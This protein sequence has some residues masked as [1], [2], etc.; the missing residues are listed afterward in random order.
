MKEK[1]DSQHYKPH[2]EQRG[3]TILAS[4]ILGLIF[5]SFFFVTPIESPGYIRLKKGVIDAKLRTVPLDSTTPKITCIFHPILY[6]FDEISIACSGLAESPDHL[7]WTLERVM[8]KDDIPVISTLGPNFSGIIDITSLFVLQRLKRNSEPSLLIRFPLIKKSDFP[9]L[10]LTLELNRPDSSLFLKASKDMSGHLMQVTAADKTIPL[11][12]DMRL[13][14]SS[15][16]LFAFLLPD[17]FL[18]LTSIFPSGALAP[19]WALL[20]L[21]LSIFLLLLSITL[22][23]HHGVEIEEHK[24]CCSLSGTWTF[25]ALFCITGFLIR[26][27]TMM[28]PA[29]NFDESYSMYIIQQP[30]GDFFRH[31]LADKHPPLY[32]ILLKCWSLL[33]GSSVHSLRF[34]SVLFST[35]MIPVVF[36]F[37][38]NLL[39]QRSAFLA[40]FFLI[41]YPIHLTYGYEIRMYAL[42]GLLSSLTFYFMMRSHSGRKKSLYLLFFCNISLFFTHY[43]GFFIIIAGALLLF[44]R[45]PDGWTFRRLFW[46]YFSQ[47]CLSLLWII[48]NLFYIRD[49]VIQHL[50]FLSPTLLHH[51]FW[52]YSPLARVPDLT[53]AD[54]SGGFVFTILFITGL[55]VPLRTRHPVQRLLFF[56]FVLVLGAVMVASYIFPLYKLRTMFILLPLF[57][58]AWS[59]GLENIFKGKRYLCAAILVVLLYFT[60]FIIHFNR[61][62]SI[63]DMVVQ[64][65]ETIELKFL[66]SGNHQAKKKGKE[67]VGAPPKKQLS[68][69]EKLSTIK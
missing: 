30:W 2:R 21:I 61:E 45:K 12:L 8:L 46:F 67:I 31:L 32:Y 47:F 16:H 35:M 19:S 4:I 27:S 15:F 42:L 39:N 1:L 68:G 26:Y 13:R 66:K 65:G 25:L 43:F 6:S 51:Y 49:A 29:V 38:K 24:D 58:I 41:F 14:N 20:F 54:W 7:I 18:P 10:K 64:P 33:F 3:R 36:L 62:F 48:P 22:F 59:V 57:P 5:S 60:M 55:L 28:V 44:L 34:L 63:D 17:I 40:A 52:Y 37:M 69:K 50:S 11:T 53:F 23:L 9:L 56:Y